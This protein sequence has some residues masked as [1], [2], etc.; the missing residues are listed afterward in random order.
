MSSRKQGHICVIIVLVNV[1]VHS[2][3]NVLSPVIAIYKWLTKR[4][5]NRVDNIL[6]S[7]KENEKCE[8]DTLFTIIKEN[9]QTTKS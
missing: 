4:K 1:S 9:K 6:T 2:V 3:F 5:M 7:S 8:P